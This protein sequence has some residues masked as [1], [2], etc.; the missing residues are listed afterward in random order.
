[1]PMWT[2]NIVEVVVCPAVC[3]VLVSSGSIMAMGWVWIERIWL[4]G[5]FEAIL[6]G[7][8]RGKV[9][10]W[11]SCCVGKLLRGCMGQLL[12]K[13]PGVSQPAG[14][15][16]ELSWKRNR[17][18]V[19]NEPGYRK[20]SPARRSLKKSQNVGIRRPRDGV[21]KNPRCQNS[22]RINE[23]WATEANINVRKMIGNWRDIWIAR[24]GKQ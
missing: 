11:E 7:L 8:K 17:R 22:N 6:G 5:L 13:K 24:V 20:L 23:I 12:Y 10:A 14:G 2:E 21:W 9:V 19:W 4:E 18:G 16:G 1:M 3:L 15:W